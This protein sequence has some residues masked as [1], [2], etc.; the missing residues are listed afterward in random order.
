MTHLGV[1][2]AHSSCHLRRITYPGD[3][4]GPLISS[5][6]TESRVQR[7]TKP[8]GRSTPPFMEGRQPGRVTIAAW[9]KPGSVVLE[10]RA[11]RGRIVMDVPANFL[12][13]IRTL[14]GSLQL[15]LVDELQSTFV[16]EDVGNGRCI[17]PQEIDV[18]AN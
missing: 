3:D 14:R 6:C 16:G 13:L 12:D 8:G 7:A 11:E 2:T 10:R 4:R 17:Q 1:P 9:P 15:A 5:S 18:V